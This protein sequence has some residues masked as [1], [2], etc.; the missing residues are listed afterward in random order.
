[1]PFIKKFKENIGSGYIDV[2][3]FILAAAIVISFA[4]RLF[5]V[6]IVKDQLNDLA[7]QML[8]EAETQG[9]VEVDCRHIISGSG[10]TPDDVIWEAERYSANKVQL[11]NPITVTC[12]AR[13]EIG[14][15]GEFA[16][17]P[18]NLKGKAT[19]RSEVFWK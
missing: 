13:V 18:V 5:P 7:D 3:V 16:S 11:N 4:V 9:M 17:F 15:F 14:L 19:G 12:I 8:R 2:T 1:M 10:I 6:F